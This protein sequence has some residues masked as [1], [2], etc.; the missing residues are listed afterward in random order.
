MI[1]QMEQ[2][3]PAGARA[4]KYFIIAHKIRP[5]LKF[6]QYNTAIIAFVTTNNEFSKYMIHIYS[7]YTTNQQAYM[8]KT[9]I[10]IHIISCL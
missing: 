5:R 6:P 1:E 9:R 7:E 8:M 2:S 10:L 3:H 4:P